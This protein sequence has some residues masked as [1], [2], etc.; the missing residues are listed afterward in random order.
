MREQAGRPH[1]EELNVV[2]EVV[3][4]ASG[5]GTNWPEELEF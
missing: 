1:P 2:S 5:A 3:G 4:W